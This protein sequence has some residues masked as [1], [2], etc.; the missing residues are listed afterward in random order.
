M[1]DV[2]FGEFSLTVSRKP[3]AG[4][5]DVQIPELLAKGL[6]VEVPKV[7]KDKD[8]ELVLTAASKEDAQKLALYAR[9]WGARQEPA[10]Y[11]HKIPNRRDMGDNVARLSVELLSEVK[12]ES[13][14]GRKPASTETTK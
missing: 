11:I 13:R 9:A 5:S 2:T 1:A 8:H 4:V 10:L 6:S 7:L 14:P 12:P 3:V